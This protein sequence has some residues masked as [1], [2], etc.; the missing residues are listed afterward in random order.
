MTP[1]TE[2]EVIRRLARIDQ[3]LRALMAIAAAAA[4]G[5]IAGYIQH[6]YGNTLGGWTWVAVFAAGT[7]GALWLKEVTK[8]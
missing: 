7:V 1:E 6:E 3:S 5:G 4:G 2:R 8:N